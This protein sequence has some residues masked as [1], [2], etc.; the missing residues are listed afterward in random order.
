MHE[1][2]DEMKAEHWV[3]FWQRKRKPKPPT[4]YNKKLKIKIKTPPTPTPTRLQATRKFIS[5]RVI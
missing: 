1:V 3:V 5:D 4:S 2:M